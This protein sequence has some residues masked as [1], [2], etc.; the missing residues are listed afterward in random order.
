MLTRAR[1]QAVARRW[2]DIIAIKRVSFHRSMRISDSRV[3]NC[4]WFL[5]SQPC[6]G[7]NDLPLHRKRFTVS[8]ETIFLPPSTLQLSP[9][10]IDIL[11]IDKWLSRVI[12]MERYSR[13]TFN[14]DSPLHFYSRL[15]YRLSRSTRREEY[16]F[17]Y[18]GVYQKVRRRA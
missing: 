1:I 11:S 12:E 18:S 4:S 6:R 17:E 16:Q 2:F 3:A 13:I 9:P 7:G 14:E 5:S 8:Q 15:V 10:Q